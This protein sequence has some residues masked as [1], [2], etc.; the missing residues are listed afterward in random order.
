VTDRSAYLDA[1]DWEAEAQRYFDALEEWA[2]VYDDTDS[3]ALDLPRREWRD[4]TGRLAAWCRAHAIDPAPLETF[5]ADLCCPEAPPDFDY[6]DRLREVWAACRRVVERVRA[7][8]PSTPAPVAQLTSWR[9]IT[10]ALDLPHSERDK[11]KSLNERF[12]GPIPTPKKG[13]QPIVGRVA[14]L[15]WW[16]RLAIMQADLAH[17]REGARL[18][19]EAQYT[20][21]RDGVAA[22]DI[23]GGVKRRKHPT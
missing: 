10:D 20:Y 11:V 9:E 18:S 16:N 23:S 14:L 21:G 17:Q 7:V 12:G 5:K 6:P 19:A 4:L 22:P 1:D 3:H 15:E 8:A 13:S 2:A